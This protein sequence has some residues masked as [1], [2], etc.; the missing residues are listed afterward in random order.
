[1]SKLDPTGESLESILASIRRSLAEQSTDVLADDAAPPA[2]YD[3]LGAVVPGQDPPPRFLGGGGMEPSQAPA[4]PPP[5]EVPLPAGIPAAGDQAFAGLDNPPPPASIGALLSRLPDEP[6]PP[7]P[8]AAPEPAEAPK[9]PL[10]FLVRGK[11][12]MGGIPAPAPT[13]FPQPPPPAPP[14]PAQPAASA[15]VAQPAAAAPKPALTEIVR[16]PLP[17][18]FGSSPEAAKVEVAPAP[19]LPGMG[20]GMAPGIGPAPLPGTSVAAPATPLPVSAV[21]PAETATPRGGASEGAPLAPATP[22]GTGAVDAAAPAGARGGTAS[23]VPAQPAAESASP[24]AERSQLRGLE[25]MVADLLRPMLRSWLDENM[26]RLVSA[27]LQAEAETLSRRDP[28][29][30]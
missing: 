9:D 7:A 4:M 19:P 23:S 6:P 30:P 11:D 29:K 8:A 26:P 13:A 1:M 28:K 14:A 16:G 5:A 27:A 21:R 20:P 24:A 10:W 3:S 2:S 12:R 15:G 22:A 18:F 17:P 25:A